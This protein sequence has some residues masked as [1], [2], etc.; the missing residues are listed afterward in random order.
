MPDLSE[1]FRE[2]LPIAHEWKSIGVLLKMDPHILDKI[3]SDEQG[4]V[5]SCLREMLST[6]VKQIE[7][8]PSLV[9]LAE[10]V[11]PFD[12]CVAEILLNH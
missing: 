11:K 12:Q 3:Q 2:L 5:Q 1:T 4:K 6:W 9:A 7:P 10:A 8:Q